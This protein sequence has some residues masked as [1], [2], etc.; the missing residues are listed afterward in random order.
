VCWS[1]AGPRG[2]TSHSNL[3]EENACGGAW[4]VT[5]AC[6]ALGNAEGVSYRHQRDAGYARR[7]VGVN[8]SRSSGDHHVSANLGAARRRRQGPRPRTGKR[9]GG[10]QRRGLDARRAQLH[11]RW[12]MA[13]RNTRLIPC[14]IRWATRAEPMKDS[15][16]SKV[17]GQALPTTLRKGKRSLFTTLCVRGHRLLGSRA[18]SPSS[19]GIVSA[20]A[21]AVQETAS[22]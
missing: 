1:D 15:A 7:K 8:V 14:H 6:S 18:I 22:P 19:P 11:A 4:D 13:A 9:A 20:A 5:T 10:A 17:P 3:A 2:G 16:N 12:V 21:L